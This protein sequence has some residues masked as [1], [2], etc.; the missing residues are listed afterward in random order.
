MLPLL[1]GIA[2]AL[3]VFSILMLILGYVA[4]L[5]SHHFCLKRRKKKIS[6][7][8]MDMECS[9]KEEVK[10]EVDSP[11]EENGPPVYAILENREYDSV[12]NYH[13]SLN[14]SGEIN[15]MGNVAYGSKEISIPSRYTSDRA[16]GD[17]NPAVSRDRESEGSATPAQQ[18][19][20]NKLAN[21]YSV[22]LSS[23]QNITLSGNRGQSANK[24]QSVNASGSD[25]DFE[26]ESNVA[27]ESSREDYTGVDSTGNTR[28]D[29]VDEEDANLVE[30]ISYLRHSRE[31]SDINDSEAHVAASMTSNDDRDMV[32]NATYEGH[33]PPERNHSRGE[34]REIEIER[35]VAYKSHSQSQPNEEGRVSIEGDDI[36]LFG[37]V[38]YTRKATRGDDDI[39]EAYVEYESIDLRSEH[40]RSSQPGRDGNG[41]TKTIH[42][43]DENE[44]VDVEKSADSEEDINLEKNVSYKTHER[45]DSS[46]TGL[47][48]VMSEDQNRSEENITLQGNISYKKHA[49]GKDSSFNGDLVAIMSENKDIHTPD[50]EGINLEK[51]VSYRTHVRGNERQFTGHL[52]QEDKEIDNTSYAVK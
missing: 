46:F 28:I 36:D 4:G 41:F 24:G 17:L 11:E 39:D 6:P 26:L 49:R 21:A 14:A 10:K 33:T 20:G 29:Q 35:N 12:D 2:I 40:A 34:S 25:R 1:I 52:S 44:N 32:K 9:I 43:V 19:D 23:K 8:P 42:D 48:V 5:L 30:N 50:K 31:H 37:N 18:K 7:M 45:E 3:A 51:N 27:Y 22:H 16:Q 15:L 13:N 38:S 47:I